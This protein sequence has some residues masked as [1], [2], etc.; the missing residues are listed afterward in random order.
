MKSV[1]FKVKNPDT[2]RME[3]YKKEDDPLALKKQTFKY[4]I[5]CYECSREISDKADACPH[6]GAPIEKGED[7][8]L[9]VFPDLPEDLNIGEQ[10]KDEVGSLFYGVYDERENSGLKI[11]SGN[12]YVRLYTNGIKIQEVEKPNS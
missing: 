1:R 12:V 4:N 8:E 7:G 2:G 11:N 5:N 6:C 9:L 3:D 10:I